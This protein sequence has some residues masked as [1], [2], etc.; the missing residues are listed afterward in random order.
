MLLVAE[1]ACFAVLFFFLPETRNRH[2][3]DIVAGWV[4]PLKVQLAEQAP[5]VVP[6][7]ATMEENGAPPDEYSGERTGLL[8]EDE[9]YVR[10]Y[11][12][13]ID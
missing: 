13:I 10:S 6:A 11:G 9:N 3:E 12:G 8:S 2:V 1:L 4:D 5:I 7:S